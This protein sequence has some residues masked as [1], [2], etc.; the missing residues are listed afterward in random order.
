MA[1]LGKKLFIEEVGATIR[2]QINDSIIYR[3]MQRLPFTCFW[4]YTVR[5]T[6]A[7]TISE[8]RTLL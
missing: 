7:Q 5:L 4:T 3:F 8:V 2:T 6:L 1:F